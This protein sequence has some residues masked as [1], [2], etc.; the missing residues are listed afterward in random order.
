MAS[1]VVVRNM[2]WAPLRM[3]DVH[4]KYM[5]GQGVGGCKFYHNLMS[6]T[7]SVELEERGIPHFMAQEITDR[8]FAVLNSMGLLKDPAL[9]DAEVARAAIAIA[10]LHTAIRMWQ[11]GT[12]WK[13]VDKQWK[14]VTLYS[15]HLCSALG[16]TRIIIDQLGKA[17]QGAKKAAKVED[18]GLSDQKYRLLEGKLESLSEYLEGFDSYRGHS[19]KD[20]YTMCV[21]TFM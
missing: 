6:N 11:G 1:P 2:A 4:E 17:Y 14:I 15:Q 10:Q 5:W 21:D 20:D 18:P 3:E 16:D 13:C 19:D 7:H 12:E 9:H 8:M